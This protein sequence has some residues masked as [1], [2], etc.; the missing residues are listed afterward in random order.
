M[1]YKTKQKDMLL[2]YMIL[3]SGKHIT[4]YDIHDYFRQQGVNIGMSTIYRHLEDMTAEGVVRKYATEANEAACYEYITND[5]RYESCI[6]CKC[7]LCGKLIHINCSE[8]Q[9]IEKHFLKDH[10]FKINSIKTTLYGIC[11]NCR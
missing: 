7:E 4:A 2:K 9:N 11:E 6:H 10:N 3:M 1:K 5:C 8:M